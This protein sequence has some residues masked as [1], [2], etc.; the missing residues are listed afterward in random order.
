[1]ISNVESMAII[2]TAIVSLTRRNIAKVLLT[3]KEPL[4]YGITGLNVLVSGHCCQFSAMNRK[5]S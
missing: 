3:C 1:M 4:L 2:T 5:L